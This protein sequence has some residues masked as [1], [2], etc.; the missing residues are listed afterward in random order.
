ML[1]TRADR[2]RRS[3]AGRL[4]FLASDAV[5]L[6]GDV[7]ANV[8]SIGLERR[9]AQTGLPRRQPAVREKLAERELRRLDVLAALGRGEDADAGILGLATGAEARV[10]LASAFAGS[11]GRRRRLR[12]PPTC[13]RASDVA[14]HQGCSWSRKVMRTVGG[15]KPPAREGLR[16]MVASSGAVYIPQHQLLGLDASSAAS[17]HSSSRS[18]RP[19]ACGSTF[20][21]Q[22]HRRNSGQICTTKIVRWFV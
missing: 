10:P 1:R 4:P 13:V 18:K 17:G 8:A 15:K 20:G 6:R 19:R 22:C 2:R 3:S 7:N 5:D 14:A 9:R 21:P 16:F 12:R 11:E